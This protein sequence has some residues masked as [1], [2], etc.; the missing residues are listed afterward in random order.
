MEEEAR[1]GVGRGDDRLVDEET[2]RAAGEAASIG[3]RRDDDEDPAMAPVVEGGGGV[4]EGFEQAEEL[5]RRHAEH[6]DAA[7][8]PIADRGRP[9]EPHEDAAYGDADHVISTEV[10]DETGAGPTP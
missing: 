6:D 9:E 7:G 1:E 2:Q 10:E 4:A 3:G 5:L 8:D